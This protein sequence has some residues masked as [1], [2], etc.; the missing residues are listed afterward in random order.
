[1]RQLALALA[2]MVGTAL[3]AFAQQTQLPA[4]LPGL[5]RDEG[6]FLVSAGDDGTPVVYFIAQN[7][8]HA[9]ADADLQIER[10]LNPL[11]P[12]RSA[13]RDEVLAYPEGSPVG[14]ARVGVLR[15]DDPEPV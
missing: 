2:L 14:N 9:I 12:S 6:T 13:A 3:P 11:W 7:I 1:M 5:G 15:V 4:T 8:R 10:Q